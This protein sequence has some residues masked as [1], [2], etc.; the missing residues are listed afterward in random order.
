MVVSYVIFFRR[1]IMT[2][3]I[4]TMS[5][6]ES[7]KTSFWWFSASPCGLGPKTTAFFFTGLKEES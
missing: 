3:D 2:Y 1:N 5:S 4:T 6:F 7:K